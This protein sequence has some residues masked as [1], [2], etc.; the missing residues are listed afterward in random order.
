MELQGTIKKIE[1]EKQVSA[2][3]KKRDFV[4]TT[5][6]E[7]GKYEQHV[8]IQFVQDKCSLLDSV[9]VGDRVKV[10]IGINGKE[11]INPE[12][13]AKYFNSIQA[14]RIDKLN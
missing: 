13:E 4:L 7:D 2:S 1:Q 8:L 3:F 11:W 9:Q 5:A 12:G 14:W 10:G 6:N